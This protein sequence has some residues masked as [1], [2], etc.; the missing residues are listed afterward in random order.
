MP[1][2]IAYNTHALCCEVLSRTSDLR[3]IELFQF[4][5]KTVPLI[6]FPFFIYAAWILF[7]SPNR[8]CHWAFFEANWYSY[9]HGALQQSEPEWPWGA[10]KQIKT[11][12]IRWIINGNNAGWRLE[13]IVHFVL[14]S[15]ASVRFSGI[16][17]TWWLAPLPTNN[18]NNDVM[19]SNFFH[20]QHQ[21]ISVVCCCCSCCWCLPLY[22]C[23]LWK[24]Q[25]IAC[26]WF[27][28]S[29]CHFVNSF[30]LFHN[31]HS[32]PRDSH[33]AHLSAAGANFVAGVAK[34]LYRTSWLNGAKE[35]R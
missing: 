13:T 21:F 33:S 17:S 5:P 22:A 29:S 3:H 7:N 19:R 16:F 4:Q 2:H 18:H 31:S 20:Y 35:C 1:K 15:H 11:R 8:K 34:N 10:T 32:H 23:L 9:N 6:K 25:K 24:W 28:R 14:C 26:L 27:C 30:W 12:I